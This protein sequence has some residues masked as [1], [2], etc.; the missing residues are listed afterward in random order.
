MTT[1]FDPVQEVMQKVRVYASFLE[2]KVAA[3][4]AAMGKENFVTATDAS[5]R[6]SAYIA[7]QNRLYSLFPEIKTT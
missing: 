6:Y 2:G 1:V 3:E 5:E 4:E 7:A